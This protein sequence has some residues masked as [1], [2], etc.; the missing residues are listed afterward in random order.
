MMIDDDIHGY[1]NVA[2]GEIYSISE[3]ANIA[4][5]AC[6]KPNLKIIYDEKMPDGQYRKDIDTTKLHNIFKGKLKFISLWDGIANIYNEYKK[7]RD[8]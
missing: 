7:E 5:Q 8:K 1:F 4:I 6:G 3:I 2:P